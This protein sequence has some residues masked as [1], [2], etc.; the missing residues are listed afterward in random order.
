MGGGNSKGGDADIPRIDPDAGDATIR[1]AGQGLDHIPPELAPYEN[2][3]DLDLSGNALPKVPL[4]LALVSPRLRKL[5][6]SGNT[7]LAQSRAHDST[8]IETVDPN[9]ARPRRHF[10]ADMADTGWAS[11]L[12]V[13][14]V[15]GCGIGAW[16]DRV[17]DLWALRELDLAGNDIR[18]VGRVGRALRRLDL[19]DNYYPVSWDS[20]DTDGGQGG[21]RGGDGGSTDAVI[22]IGGDDGANLRELI[23][24]C[25]NEKYAKESAL[26]FPKALGRFKSLEILV[27][28]SQGIDTLPDGMDT[29]FPALSCVIAGM[30]FFFFFLCFFPFFFFFCDSIWSLIR[31]FCS[32]GSEPLVYDLVFICVC[33]LLLL[34]FQFLFHLAAVDCRWVLQ[35]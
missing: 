34:L 25:R 18:T 31:P 32:K 1:Y 29:M 13:L 4:E 15:R 9:R 23:V 35:F 14:L 16:D 11:S 2:L 5:N 3:T 6:L 24:T 22:D 12:E 20:V 27:L 8:I 19:S 17:A 21:Q 30:F 10:L 26:R 7:A 28:D 33:L